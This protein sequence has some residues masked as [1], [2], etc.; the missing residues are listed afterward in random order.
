MPGSKSS[1]VLYIT[2]FPG[3]DESDL[4]HISSPHD[5]QTGLRKEFVQQ[6]LRR[7]GKLAEFAEVG[8]QLRN[9]CN[10]H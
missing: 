5:L 9:S 7:R 3:K 1:R 10:N 8:E 2:F 6:E 4:L